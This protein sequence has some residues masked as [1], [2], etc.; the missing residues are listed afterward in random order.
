MVVSAFITS[1]LKHAFAIG[2]F[3]YIPFIVIDM[4]VA[5]TVGA[6]SHPRT[7]I[8]VGLDPQIV[9]R[10]RSLAESL[11][12]LR[13]KLEELQKISNYL[14]GK[15]MDSEEKGEKVRQVLTTRLEYMQK[16][17]S[18]E[19]EYDELQSRLEGASDGVI[20]ILDTVYPGATLEISNQSYPVSG[21]P[22]RNAT[23][24]ILEKE[25]GMTACSY[26]KRRK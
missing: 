3:I 7:K 11:S 12:E 16:V 20:H 8:E 4:V 1:E 13:R 14:M 10:S 21:N 5:Q 26:S 24:R 25:I 19:A 2:L 15:A 9:K 23:F 22:I 6:P 18:M 17:R